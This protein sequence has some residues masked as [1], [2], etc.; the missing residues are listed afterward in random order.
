MMSY[1][2]VIFRLILI[3]G[4]CFTLGYVFYNIGS[5]QDQPVIITRIE[6]S[7]GM[8][9]E[10]VSLQIKTREEKEY[11]RSFTMEDGNPINRLLSMF[12]EQG[13]VSGD[14]DWKENLPL[15]LTERQLKAFKGEVFIKNSGNRI[16]R[17]RIDNKYITGVPEK[18]PSITFID[19][20]AF[21]FF[22]GAMFMFYLMARIIT[23]LIIHYKKNGGIKDFSYPNR[24]EDSVEGWK[25][26]LGFK[27]KK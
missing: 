10:S 1:G 4:V 12:Q 3:Q 13:M 5:E 24:L 11:T 9:M 23:I 7:Q 19:F 16:D 14:F 20:L 21:F 17:L 26:I 2:Y 22:L 6:L 8:N 27:T 18:K 15:V 25:Y